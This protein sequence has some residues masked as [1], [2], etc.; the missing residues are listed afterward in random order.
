MTISFRRAG[1]FGGP[2]G[3]LAALVA[4]CAPA[5]AQDPPMSGPP[6][7][8]NPPAQANPPA[9][10]VRAPLVVSVEGPSSV[11]V[12]TTID[13]VAHI[14]RQPATAIPFDVTIE[15]PKGAIVIAGSAS[16]R[17]VD[18][19]SATVDRSFKLRIDALPLGDLVVNVDQ[20]APGFGVH[21]V[22]HYRFGRPEPKLPQPHHASAPLG[23]NGTP[24]G[25]SISMSR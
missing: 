20:R 1:H 19:A 14:R 2:L 18:A 25:R 13:V 6:Q 12:G 15:V 16:E 9:S 3:I 4:G 10:D 11:A 24:L 7:T 8:S 5:V 17:I 22:G 23:F 21:A